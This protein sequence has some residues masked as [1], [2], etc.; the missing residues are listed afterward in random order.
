MAAECASRILQQCPGTEA[1]H[2]GELNGEKKLEHTASLN[3]EELNEIHT[4]FSILAPATVR[5]PSSVT[6]NNFKKVLLQFMKVIKTL[7]LL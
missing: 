6:F 2:S 4:R 3:I 5:F 7:F 1:G